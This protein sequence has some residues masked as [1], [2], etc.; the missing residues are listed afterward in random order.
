MLGRLGSQEGCDLI[1]L[2]EGSPR[3][4]PGLGGLW[5]L[6]YKAT[7]PLS[8]LTARNTITVIVVTAV[9]ADNLGRRGTKVPVNRGGKKSL[10]SVAQRGLLGHNLPRTLGIPITPN[11][12]GVH[13][14]PV[15][16]VCQVCPGCRG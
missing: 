1:C 12:V 13:S 7:S 3:L 9:T 15:P 2:L 14:S 10:L 8:S 16:L 4:R 11:L 5:W 6:R